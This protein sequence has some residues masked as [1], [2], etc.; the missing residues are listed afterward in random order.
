MDYKELVTVKLPRL[1]A[2]KDRHSD[3]RLYPVE[4]IVDRAAGRVKIHYI[5]YSAHYDEEMTV[6]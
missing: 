1:R 3:S 6:M 2:E 5:G 4:V